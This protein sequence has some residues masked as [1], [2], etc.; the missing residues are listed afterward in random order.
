MGLKQPRFGVCVFWWVW[1]GSNIA[2]LGPRRLVEKL[3]SDAHL[4][5]SRELAPVARHPP[6]KKAWRWF[7]S[8]SRSSLWGYVLF[9]GSGN[10]W[11]YRNCSFLRIEINP[12]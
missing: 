10:L 6:F 11:I 9:N 1:A 3:L 2:A 5:P 7:T 4:A 8:A 12:V